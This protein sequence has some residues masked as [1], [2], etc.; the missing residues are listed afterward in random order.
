M[1]MNVFHRF[2]TQHCSFTGMLI[3]VHFLYHRNV[4]I[5]QV[6]ENHEIHAQSQYGRLSN[7]TM[8]GM[9]ENRHKCKKKYFFVPWL[10]TQTGTN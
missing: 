7:T 4:P 2:S 1:I 8:L 6:Q 3:I 5:Y 9:F 10:P